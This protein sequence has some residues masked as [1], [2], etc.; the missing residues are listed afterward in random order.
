MPEAQALLQSAALAGLAAGLLSRLRSRRPPESGASRLDPR[1]VSRLG[2]LALLLALTP[3]LCQGLP[4]GLVAAL[5]VAYGLGLCDDLSPWSPGAKLV[6]QALVGLLM[7]EA[8]IIVDLTRFPWLVAPATVAWF[9]LVMNAL[10]LLDNMD[11]LASAVGLAAAL[12]LYLAGGRFGWEAGLLLALAGG[13]LGL[14]IWNAPPARVYLGD[15]GAYLTGA[16][17]AAMAVSATWRAGAS[18][19]ATI[20]LPALVLAVPLTDTI[21]VTLARWRG[22]RPITRGGV[23]HLSHRLLRRGWRPS[24]VALLFSAAG[25]AC[26]ALALALLDG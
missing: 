4:F 19:L 24:A 6:G 15:G 9:V 23:D 13:L 18:L 8:G 20:A 11:G 25:A 10:N 12:V 1:P 21:F 16:V 5:I 2:G 22:G 7:W 17:L 3:A 14:L 26:G